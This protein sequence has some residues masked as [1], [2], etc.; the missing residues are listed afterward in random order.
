M[1]RRRVAAY[2]ILAGL[3]ALTLSAVHLAGTPSGLRGPRIVESLPEYPLLRG[4]VETGGRS[5][6]ELEANLAA[7][8]PL[9][10]RRVDGIKMDFN[11]GWLLVRPSGTEPKIRLTAEARTDTE[12]RRLYDAGLQAVKDSLKTGGEPN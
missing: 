2:A 8:K 6:S 4:S 3:F 12:A 9:A 10:T 7:L 11:D 5:L 1:Q